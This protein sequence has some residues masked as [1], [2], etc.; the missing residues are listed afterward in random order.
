VW[1]GKLI[2]EAKKAFAKMG[3][4]IWFPKY[5]QHPIRAYLP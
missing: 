5:E 3:V 4:L 2:S 1:L